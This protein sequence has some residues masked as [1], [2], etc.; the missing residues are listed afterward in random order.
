MPSGRNLAPD[1]L[2]ALAESLQIA[3]LDGIARARR[4]GRSELAFQGGTCLHL[5]Y[6]SPRASEDLDFI[7]ASDKGLGA[8]MNAELARATALL[9]P[10]AGS[11]AA[12]AMK[13]R[14][15][16]PETG[17]PRNPRIYTVSFK[18]PDYL[19][20]VKVKVGFWVTD[21]AI[22]AGYHSEPVIA[23]ACVEALARGPI[24]VGIEQ[25][26]IPVA[27]MPEIMTDKIQALAAREYL[28]PRDAFDLWWLS[29]QGLAVPDT[30]ALREAL[31]HRRTLYPDGL[32]SEKE[33]AARLLERAQELEVPENL[34]AIDRDLRRWLALSGSLYLRTP[35]FA[36]A[37]AAKAADIARLAASRIAPARARAKRR[38]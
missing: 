32:G 37:V 18:S 13:V 34:A 36:R 14:A 21:P 7:L 3:L 27:K 9:R 26:I 35:E 24:K 22:A 31:T 5:A 6:G 11:N 2:Q 25:A 38:P 8:V 33:V 16:D 23:K 15:E 20:A 10:A 19:E 4:W 12:L 17:A 30:P 29:N 28:M 1:E